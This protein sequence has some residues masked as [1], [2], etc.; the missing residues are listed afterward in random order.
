MF[1]PPAPAASVEELLAAK[2]EAIQAELV[3]VDHKLRS[4]AWN[5][6]PPRA[7]V[8]ERWGEVALGFADDGRDGGGRVARQ[9]GRS[10]THCSAARTRS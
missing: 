8:A 3:R 5:A 6:G 2:V 1:E 9:A 4:L 7:R 10:S